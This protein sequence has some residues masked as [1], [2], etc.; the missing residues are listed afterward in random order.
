MPQYFTP[1]GGLTVVIYVCQNHMNNGNHCERS[2]E[3][4][5]KVTMGWGVCEAHLHQA[6]KPCV[7]GV[8]LSQTYVN[9]WWWS[10]KYFSTLFR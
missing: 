10:P 7:I 3:D 9:V 1:G 8:I 2:L 6:Q 5:L 4:H